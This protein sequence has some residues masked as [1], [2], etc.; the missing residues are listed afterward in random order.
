M[1]KNNKIYHADFKDV[2][3]LKE[4]WKEAFAEED[5][6]INL[7]F[8]SLFSSANVICV[9]ENNTICSALYLLE[10]KINLLSKDYKAFY[11][12]AAGTLNEH[13]NKGYMG[14][15]LEYAKVFC[16]KLE[17]EAICLFPASEKLY[18]YYSKRDY[19]TVFKR[20][21]LQLEK[22][23]IRLLAS[24][25]NEI[26]P[27]TA[28]NIKLIRDKALKNSD[29][30]EWN[31]EILAYQLSL[32]SL[33]AGEAF[34]LFQDDAPVA[35]VISQ[36]Q[37]KDTETLRIKEA[38]SINNDFSQISAIL[39]NAYQ[40]QDFLINLPLNCPLTSDKMTVFDDGMLLP[41]SE[42][43]KNLLNRIKFLY[44]GLNLG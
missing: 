17:A 23:T 9:K 40:A 18:D 1:E 5:A 11:V 15:L 38:L 6:Y 28:E 25:N 34:V 2:P 29:F 14:E 32:N 3:G 8:E 19:L 4:L 21:E 44:M 30:L 16:K 13:R 42:D 41:L 36:M 37:D 7:F 20:K 10:C 43:V 33:D 22:Q 12:Y 39:L 31:T 35:Y 27:A 24:K 26:K